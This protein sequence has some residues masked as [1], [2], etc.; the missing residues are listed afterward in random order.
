MQEKHAF[1]Q[2]SFYLQGIFCYI[3]E[4]DK[5]SPDCKYKHILENGAPSDKFE[6]FYCLLHIEIHGFNSRIN[7]L[8]YYPLIPD[9][10]STFSKTVLVPLMVCC[11]FSSKS[12]N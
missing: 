11:K 5:S 1:A 8:G 4:S 6:V 7:V 9:T 12:L 10:N 2:E 3:N